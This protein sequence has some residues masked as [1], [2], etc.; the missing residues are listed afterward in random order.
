MRTCCI[1]EV[2]SESFKSFVSRCAVTCDW[3]ILL[4]FRRVESANKNRPFLSSLEPLFQSESKC[5]IFV[6]VISFNFNMNKKLIFLTK[7]SHLA[8]L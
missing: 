2:E 1:K 4:L 6:M 8:S 3:P 5:E 7:T